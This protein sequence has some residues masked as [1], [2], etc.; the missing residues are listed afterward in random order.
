MNAQLEVLQDKRKNHQNNLG[1]LRCKEA[2]AERKRVC[3]MLGLLRKEDEDLVRS[4]TEPLPL[5]SVE[6]SSNEEETEEEEL[7][8][9]PRTPSYVA[10]DDPAQC[11]PS[12]S[13]MISSTSVVPPIGDESDDRQKAD[14]TFAASSTPLPTGVD[15]SAISEEL[16]KTHSSRKRQKDC[17]KSQEA[18][19]RPRN[20]LFN[21]FRAIQR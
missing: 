6:D 1:T 19:K 18:N 16:L 7:F 9:T 3:R 2:L 4:L 20:T 17:V 12:Y 10:R 8:V 14:D 5:A 15:D 11:C 13:A 21:Y